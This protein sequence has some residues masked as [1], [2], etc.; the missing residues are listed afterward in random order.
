MP[1]CPRSTYWG[2]KLTSSFRIAAVFTDFH[3][4]LEGNWWER[5]MHFREPFESSELKL[6]RTDGF[7][8]DCPFHSSMK[9]RWPVVNLKKKKIQKKKKFKKKKIQ[10]SKHWKVA[11]L[12]DHVEALNRRRNRYPFYIHKISYFSQSLFLSP[13]FQSLQRSS[14]AIT[15]THRLAGRS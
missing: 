2:Q 4:R 13:P 15:A 12:R 7:A 9:Y 6:V 3:N 1:A 11:F 5:R 10:K 8:N 14:T